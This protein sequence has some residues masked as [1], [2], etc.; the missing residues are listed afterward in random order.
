MSAIP[1]TRRINVPRLNVSPVAV[2]LV[3]ATGAMGLAEYRGLSGDGVDTLAASSGASP[4]TTHPLPVVHL[5][6]AVQL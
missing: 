3:N 2:G 4:V 5:L 6:L 1:H